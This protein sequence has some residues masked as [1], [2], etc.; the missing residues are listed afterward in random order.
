MLA[1]HCSVTARITS[2]PCTASMPTTVSPAAGR[3]NLRPLR[4]PNVRL[5]HAD[6]SLGLSV[7]APFDSIV[8]AA[9][10]TQVPAALV[11]QLA[12]G[13]RMVLPVGS[14]DQIMLL[15]ERSASGVVKETKLDAVRF[16]PL[17]P[18]TE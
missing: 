7:V 4:L 11:D 9:A 2:L 1:R 16:V 18:G 15:I 6:G 10:A 13:G 5:K 14:K 8:L 12:P 3:A 17:L